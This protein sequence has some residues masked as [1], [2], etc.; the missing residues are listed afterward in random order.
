VGGC[1]LQTLHFILNPIAGHGS[2]LSAFSQMESLLRSRGIRY[3]V[4]RS[5]Y[6]GHARELAKKALKSRAL[7]VAVGGD[8]T[9]HE[10]SSAMANT[11]VPMGIFP[12]GTG[13]DAAR[14]LKIPMEPEKVLDLLLHKSPQLIDM[15]L[16]ND[17]Y[18]LNVGGFGFDVDVLV[19]TEKYKKRFNRGMGAYLLGIFN[20]LCKLRLIKTTVKTENETFT[21]NA[22]LVSA[23]NGTHFGGGMNVAPQAD[24]T[25]GLFDVCIA[26]DVNRFTVLRLLAKFV[27]GKHLGL[28][29][30]IR[31][32]RA[33]EVSFLTPE[34]ISVQVDGEIIEKAPVTFRIA[35]KA[36]LLVTGL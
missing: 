26:S 34:G 18:F 28:P 6:P 13:N 12:C 17:T 30:F 3:T 19:N 25:D 9:V 1:A 29:R 21:T 27:K 22:L 11:G 5:A 32:F 33:K 35:P 15:G 23:A 10:V 20:S 8:G 31:Y 7:V 2:A 14:P 4:V 24:L 16:A 36:L